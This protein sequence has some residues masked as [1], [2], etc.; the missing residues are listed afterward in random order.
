MYCPS[1]STQC[2]EG[3]KFCKACGMSLTP[4]TQALSGGTSISDPA[5]EREYKRSRKQVSDGIRG[6][7]VG[8]AVLISSALAYFLLPKDRFSSVLALV[9]ALIGLVKLFKSIGHIIDAK[10]GQMIVEPVVIQRRATGPLP[11]LSPHSQPPQVIQSPNKLL[12]DPAKL[13]AAQMQKEQ[14]VRPPLAERTEREEVPPQRQPDLAL[15]N[16]PR[17]SPTGRVNREH[18]SPLVKPGKEDVLS[19][20]RN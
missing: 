17:V 18:S 16:I 6:I 8:A 9:L 20:L 13:Q 5:R 11:T 2:A 19:K 15:P 1:C 10:V 7:M 3:A 14:G 12:L 4:V